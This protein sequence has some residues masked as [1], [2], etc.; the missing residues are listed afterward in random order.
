MLIYTQTHQNPVLCIN[1]LLGHP[2]NKGYIKLNVSWWFQVEI[3]KDYVTFQDQL[4]SLTVER[5]Q[6]FSHFSRNKILQLVFIESHLKGMHWLL[7]LSCYR[8]A[9]LCSNSFMGAVICWHNKP[10]EKKTHYAMY[11]F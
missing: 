8:Q 2:G 4:I 1:A 10:N 7:F 3:I 6:S 9:D 5:L 11:L